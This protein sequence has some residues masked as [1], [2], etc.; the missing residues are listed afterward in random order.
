MKA[1]LGI[2]QLF[3]LL[4]L[5]DRAAAATNAP[6]ALAPSLVS[7]H[8]D[9]DE[10]FVFR[11]VQVFDGE[12]VL[13]NVTV[14]IQGR[15]IQA[16]AA[17]APAPK[18]ATIIKGEG[19]TLLPGLIDAHA[20]NDDDPLLLRQAAV[21]GVTTLLNMFT[22]TPQPDVQFRKEQDA[23]RAT[24]RADLFT[25]GIGVTAKGGHGTQYGVDIP[26]LDNPTNAQAFIDAR[27]AEGS[28][29]IKIIIEPGRVNRRVPN[30]GPSLSLETATAAAAAA[31]RRGKLAVFHAQTESA[32]RQALEA[33]ADGLVHIYNEG[34]PNWEIARMAK[35]N[36]AFV[37]PTLAL[38]EASMGMP[39]GAS[40]ADDPRLTPYIRPD[41]RENLC[42]SGRRERLGPAESYAV[43]VESVRIFNEVGVRI[44]AGSDCDNPG[45]AHGVSLHR[46]LELLVSAGL[47][48]LEALRAATSATADSFHLKDRGR[49]K[50]GLRADL[51]LV[52][53][54]P[55]KDIL[56]TRDIVGVWKEGW[57]ID[58]EAFKAELKEWKP[59]TESSK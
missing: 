9:Q 19:M 17:E 57:A 53:G 3:C 50:P 31:K 18:G 11:D 23:G 40:L 55:M 4:A 2:L 45:T 27:I 51:L 12:S 58:R 13:S 33:G 34:V 25:A 44:L 6:R 54:D 22:C 10:A 43:S 1:L 49:I 35:T 32:T 39:G 28:D 48:P 29:Y 21:F 26:T 5:C 42:K 46:E 36:G 15:T 37:I 8:A 47:T 20:H 14:V 41:Q 52:K 16:V 24:N 59:K 38:I 30:P 56:A 7:N